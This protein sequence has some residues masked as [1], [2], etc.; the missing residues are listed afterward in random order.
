MGYE[1]VKGIRLDLKRNRVHITSASNNVQPRIFEKYVVD[2]APQKFRD[3]QELSEQ[4]QFL[5]PIISDL[6]CGHMEL[7][8]SVSIHYRYALLQST[9]KLRE[10]SQNDDRFEAPYQA[11]GIT[12]PDGTSNL[13]NV[14]TVIDQFLQ[15]LVRPDSECNECIS[16][17]GGYFLRFTRNGYIVVRD[18]NNAKVVKSRKELECLMIEI[19]DLTQ[20]IPVFQTA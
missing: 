4:E 14:K 9:M 16:V 3:I 19:P 2:E 10:I 18:M 17:P 13:D 15:S 12:K 8:R 11:F 5:Y 6:I 20:A 1:L 7:Q